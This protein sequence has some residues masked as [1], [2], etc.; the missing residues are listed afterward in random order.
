MLERPENTGADQ[1]YADGH[2]VVW[3]KISSDSFP[4]RVPENPQQSRRKWGRLISGPHDQ[5]DT[6]DQEAREQLE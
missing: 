1:C 5:E 6:G 4:Y 2:F 3:D